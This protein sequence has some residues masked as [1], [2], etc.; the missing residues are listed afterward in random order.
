MP[1][2]PGG[3]R[4]Y[5]D[6]SSAP[7][8]SGRQLSATDGETTAVVSEVGGN[9]RALSHGR[10][11]L[12]YGY[13]QSEICSGGRG[14]VL[15]PWPNRLD[16]GRYEFAGMTAQAP[17]DE[18]DAG[19]A[20]HGLMRWLRW[21]L[22]SPSPDVVLAQCEL[23]AQPGY[24]WGLAVSVTYTVGGSSWLTV[25]VAATNTGEVDHP[26]PFGAGFH[27]YLHAGPSTV[28][29]CLLAVPAA[30]RLVVDERGIPRSRE[31]VGGTT[32]D[33]RQSRRVGAMRLDDCFTG[34]PDTWAVTFRR[35]D[36]LGVELWAAKGWPFVMCYS[37]DT[38]A[39]ADRRRALAVEP[40]TC[41][42]NA[43]ATGESLIVLRPEETW[44]GRWGIGPEGTAS[45]KGL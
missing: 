18:P 33:F 9:L 27:P 25:D 12:V 31:P 42:P 24:P 20:I 15:V 38:L 45:L 1:G 44:T 35:G 11:A 36:G 2:P 40:M 4:P 3:G 22:S 34:L 37:G 43:L 7:S 10:E 17:I 13:P 5:A 14:Q 6:G 39:P 26:A 21:S 23:A 8:P 32:R 41:P 16:G 28:D 30:S 29:T 19:N